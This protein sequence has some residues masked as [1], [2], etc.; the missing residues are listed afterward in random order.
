MGH[1]HLFPG[2]FGE[3][4]RDE[5]GIPGTAAHLGAFLGR[6]GFAQAQVLAPHEAP[7]SARVKARIAAGEDGLDWLLAQPDVGLAG[8]ARFLPAATIRPNLPDAPER[9]R[10]A[11]DAGVRLLKFHPLIMQCD[12][13]SPACAAFFRAAADGRMSTVYHTGGGG[14]DWHADAG[15]PTV[16]AELARRYPDLPILMAHCGVFGDVDEFDAAVEACTAHANLHLDTTA[17]LVEVGRDRWRRALD[18]LGPTRVVYG[19]DYPWTS[20]ASVAAELEFIRALGLS[21]D[22]EARVLGGNLL[23]LWRAAR[24]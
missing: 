13:L 12:P 15:R 18:R 6:C 5:M 17:A 1:C 19:T 9:L 11:R 21:A 24:S 2:G 16:C 7:R 20:L 8:D 3:G 14:W 22:D 4:A 10:R 23:R